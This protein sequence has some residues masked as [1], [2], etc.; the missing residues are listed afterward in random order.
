MAGLLGVNV[1]WIGRIVY[2]VYAAITGA[3]GIF[4][5][6]LFAVSPEVGLQYTTFAFFT[7]VL[8]GMGYVPGVPVAGLTLGLLQS[9]VATYWGPRYVFLAVFF[10]LYLILLILPRG[11]LGRGWA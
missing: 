3:A 11:V 10:V 2:A 8:A 5:G 4:I 9:I 1:D 7:V 6:M